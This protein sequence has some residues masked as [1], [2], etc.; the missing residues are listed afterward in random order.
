MLERF[1][2][3]VAWYIV[4]D[5]Q[6]MDEIWSLLLIF[7]LIALNGT[8]VA[9]EFSVA[10]LRRTQIDELAELDPA[11][12]ANKS[13]IRHAKALQKVLA[14][15]NDYISACQVGITISSLALGAVAELKIEAWISPTVNR[16]IN[17]VTLP[18]GITPM[19]SEI[20]G[21]AIAITLAIALITFFHVILGEIV[22]KN[23]ALFKPVETSMSLA[24]FL[25]TLHS[26]F[27][28]PVWVLNSCS[29]LCLRLLKVDP[30]ESGVIHTEDELKLI[31]SSSQEVGVLEEEEEELLQNIFEFNDTVAKN[32][33]TPRTDMICLKEELSIQEAL[34]EMNRSSHSRFPIYKGRLDNMTGYVALKDILQAI[35]RGDINKP[36]SSIKSEILKITDGIFIIDLMKV[37]QKKKKQIAI[38]IDE[39]GGTSGLVTIEDIVEEIFGEI[40]DEKEIS[41]TRI[42]KLN[43]GIYLVDGAVSLDDLNSELDTDFKSDHYDTIGGFTYGLIGEE[44]KVG[45]KVEYEGY[46]ITVEKH[47]N[48]RI[49]QVRLQEMAVV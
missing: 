27:K 40:E 49:K 43:Q 30:D 15:I 19:T 20:S 36:L 28:F 48:H 22:P 2:K 47:A 41:K 3:L 24:Y 8:F 29:N 17:Q 44:P 1:D 45:D 18:V 4:W 46:I 21:H 34:S 7:S 25:T 38:L 33:M 12:P 6:R 35:E 9:A 5:I 11:E 32:I 23:I 42:Q 39:F 26:I 37:M 31:L 13:K 16:L 10:R 14:N